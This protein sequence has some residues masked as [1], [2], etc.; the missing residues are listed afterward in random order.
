MIMILSCKSNKK[1][2]VLR[3]ES[4]VNFP[5]FAKIFER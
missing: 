4:E 1:F 3:V 5:I 2:E